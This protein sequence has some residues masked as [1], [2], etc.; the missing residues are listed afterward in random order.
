[1]TTHILVFSTWTPSPFAFFRP[2]STI[3][4]VVACRVGLNGMRG[5]VDSYETMEEGRVR[6]NRLFGEWI[7]GLGE[8]FEMSRGTRVTF[9]A[10]YGLFFG[11]VSNGN[12]SFQRR[13][14]F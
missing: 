2:F 13:I 8:A 10:G 11:G 12:N 3:V 6:V 14:F 9:L 5:V 7:C 4:A 1:M